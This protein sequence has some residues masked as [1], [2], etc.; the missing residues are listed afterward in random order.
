MTHNFGQP[1]TNLPPLATRKPVKLRGAEILKTL[2]KGIDLQRIGQFAEAEFHYQLVLYN[3]PDNAQALNL[4]GTLAIEAESTK[5]AIDFMEKAVKRAP[6]NALFRNN[7][8][9][10]YLLIR[11]YKKAKQHLEKAIKLDPKFVEA[12]CNLGKSYRLLLR[13]PEAEKYYER[14]LRVKPDSELALIGMGE[15]LID[16]GRPQDAAEYFHKALAIN[17]KSAESLSGLANSRKFAPDD[18]EL[19]LILERI[20]DPL[21]SKD[22][23]VMLHYAAGKILNDQQEY[24]Q[25]IRHYSTGKDLSGNDFSIELHTELYDSFI[26]NFDRG[27][28]MERQD[29]GDP[30]QRPV[31]IVGMPRSGTTLTEQICASHPNIYG[32]GE[33][34]DIRGLTSGLGFSDLNTQVFVD[35][36]KSMTKAQSQELARK[37]LAA[38]KTSDKSAIHVVDKM[39]HNYE[40]LSLITLIFPNARIINCNRDPMD[41]CLSCFMH[42]FSEFHG[43]NADLTTIGRYYRQYDRLMAHWNTALPRKPL[44]MQ[45]E[46]TVDDIETRARAMIDYIGLEWND[47]CLSFYETKR[48]VRTPSRWQVRQPIYKTAVKRWK[49]YGDNLAP[50]QAALGDLVTE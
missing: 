25:A 42:N 20:K 7:L 10:A 50:L 48:T 21:T 5:T 14:A 45:Y 1:T 24:D 34:T 4:M 28:F 40:F 6:K 2:Q 35:A 31:F 47:A 13:G 43:Y 23:L 3:E 29:L 49:H 22:Q 38:L 33:L 36:M 19:E 26:K 18:P 11:D 37:Y 32:A 8:G 46:E 44:K 41:N 17:P 16:N 30:S 39:P 15:L 27:F 9:N 12:L